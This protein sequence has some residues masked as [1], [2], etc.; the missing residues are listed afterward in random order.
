MGS[1]GSFDWSQA[2]NPMTTSEVEGFHFKHKDETG[3]EGKFETFAGLAMAS[4][5]NADQTIL[6]NPATNT[7]WIGQKIVDIPIKGITDIIN[8]D[9]EYV[10]LQ[11]RREPGGAS[12]KIRPMNELEFLTIMLRL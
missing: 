2:S 12:Y 8:K 10:T 4:T 3:Y 1:L 5:E 7:F 11:I 6:E 9:T